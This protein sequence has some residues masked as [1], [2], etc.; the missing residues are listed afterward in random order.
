M[1]FQTDA[2]AM[3]SVSGGPGT[4][5]IT[6]EERAKHD[7]QFLSLKPVGG[8]VTGINDFCSEDG[9]QIG[10]HGPEI[11][12]FV[13]WK[14]KKAR[15]SFAAVRG[16]ASTQGLAMSDSPPQPPPPPDINQRR[17]QVNPPP[18][19]APHWCSPSLTCDA[20]PLHGTPAN[21]F[22]FVPKYLVWQI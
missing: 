15:S 9:F 4:W 18:E 2:I 17:T 3:N 7:Q 12:Y 10:S 6:P 11:F 20:P 16:S 14:K 5:R 1:T 8:M 22:S 13:L 21:D 19:R